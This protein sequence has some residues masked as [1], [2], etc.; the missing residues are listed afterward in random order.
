MKLPCPK[1][2]EKNSNKRKSE[3]DHGDHSRKRAKITGQAPVPRK[4]KKKAKKRTSDKEKIKGVLHQFSPNDT[5]IIISSS[6]NLCKNRMIH[7]I[8]QPEKGASENFLSSCKVRIG[9]D[10][11]MLAKILNVTGA[12]GTFFCPFCEVM[13]KNLVKGI[14]HA[15]I[16]LAKYIQFENRVRI[17]QQRTLEG[18]RE[19]ATQFKE[20]G[21]SRNRLKDFKNCEDHPLLPPE[22]N[23]PVVDYFSV[24]PLHIN[25]GLGL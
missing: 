1:Q 10:W 11:E 18:I 23:G 22:I 6:C 12:N 2:S 14:P 13:L 16:A 24:M 5:N 15:P 3:E 21:C 19:E 17:F 9:S 25:L 20:Q 7:H 4:G 8:P